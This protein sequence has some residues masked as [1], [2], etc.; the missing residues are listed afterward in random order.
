MT[1]SPAPR[2]ALGAHHPVVRAVGPAAALASL[3]LVSVVLSP[4]A[5][6]GRPAP[7]VGLDP[8]GSYSGG[9]FDESAAE[10]PAFDPGTARAFVVNAQA[11]TIDVLDLS[12]PTD[13]T[14]VGELTTPGANSV[15]VRDGLVAV[16]EQAGAVQAAGSV[17]FFHAA[18]LA[19][20]GQVRVGALPDMLTFSPDGRSLLVANEGEPDDYGPGSTDP[21]G[22]ISVVDVRRGVPAQA[23]VRTA[24]FGDWDARA[25]ELVADGV[26]LSG[27]GAT[28]SQDLEPEYVTV[29]ARSRTA[30]VS[31][32]E[33]N[34]LAVVDIGTATVTDILPL[35]LKDHSRPGAGLDPSDRDGGIAIGT[36]PVKGLYMP[37]SVATYTARGRTYVVTANEGD[38]R[39]YD[40]YRDEARVSA[41]TLSPDVFGGTA[42]VAALRAPAALGRLT[43]TT[44]SP[45][46][47]QGRVTEIHVFG[48][49]SFSIRDSAGG[50]VFD[51]GD[52][53]EQVVAERLPEGFNA[54]NDENDSADSRSDNKGP[55]PEGLAL[56][57]VAGRTYAF[58]G[59]ERVG[60][61]A[62]YD[63]TVPTRSTFV[64]YVNPRD[65]TGDLAENGSDSGP[66]GLVFVAAKDSPTG[67]PLLVVGNETSGTTTVYA[68]TRD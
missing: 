39:D 44:T 21:E 50:L 59:L 37:D 30:W 22:S 49:R 15:A 64:D 66:E 19:R 60:G 45:T 17:V 26:R 9:G 18:T 3:V 41:L 10:I 13:P 5:E 42:G 31:L 36:W 53:L 56:G 38:S 55:E 34:A 23:D 28:V 35:G 2:P 51:S 11:G 24:G 46:D 20:L 25:A 61:I 67:G 4:P 16:A 58:V 12:D 43:A 65:L 1:L 47:A 6:A 33:A 7:T 8:L 27:P 62:V 40:G 68:V 52:Q 48:G 29:D 54:D 14:K 63:V 57:T 32:Q